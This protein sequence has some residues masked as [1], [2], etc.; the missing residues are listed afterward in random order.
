MAVKIDKMPPEINGDT[1]KDLENIRDY[2]VYL[3][4]QINFALQALEN[5]LRGE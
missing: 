5:D 3:R 1:K 4:E 2:I